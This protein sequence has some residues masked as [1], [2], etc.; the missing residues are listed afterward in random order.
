[1]ALSRTLIFHP[2]DLGHVYAV[3][4][5]WDRHLVSVGLPPIYTSDPLKVGPIL[6]GPDNFGKQYY[7]Y[8]IDSSNR[9][10][11]SVQVL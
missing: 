1:M 4:R 10:Y 6:L 8:Q 9:L 2:D 3:S 11:L 7:E 5:A